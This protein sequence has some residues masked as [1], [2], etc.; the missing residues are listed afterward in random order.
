ML[1]T[2]MAAN[3]F[4]VIIPNHW[5]LVRAKEGGEPPDPAGTRAARAAPCTTTT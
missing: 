1:G 3:V 2:V 4:F 5:K